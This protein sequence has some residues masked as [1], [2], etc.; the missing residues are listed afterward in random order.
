MITRRGPTMDMTQARKSAIALP[1]TTLIIL[2]RVYLRDKQE[3]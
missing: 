1:E 2:K 3:E